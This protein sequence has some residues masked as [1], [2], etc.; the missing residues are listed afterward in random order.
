MLQQQD[1]FTH[2]FAS[3]LPVASLHLS[4]FGKDIYYRETQ[5]LHQ[6][7]T[8]HFEI[9]ILNQRYKTRKLPDYLIRWKETFPVILSISLKSLSRTK[10]YWIG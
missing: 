2:P 4:P 3:F 7:V 5:M 9:F 1:C 8:H 6:V 10:S